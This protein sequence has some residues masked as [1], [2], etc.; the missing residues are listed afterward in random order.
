MFSWNKSIDQPNQGFPKRLNHENYQTTSLLNLYSFP[1]EGRI[2]SEKS[3]SNLERTSFNPWSANR[4]CSNAWSCRFL[5]LAHIFFHLH[6]IKYLLDVVRIRVPCYHALILGPIALQDPKKTVQSS[7]SRRR[8]S[9]IDPKQMQPRFDVQEPLGISDHADVGVV[10]FLLGP[11]PRG[12]ESFTD[13]PTC[14]RNPNPANLRPP[15]NQNQ[16]YQ[17]HV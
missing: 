15:T 12:E 11:T 13:H 10:A 14:R 7:P 5:L 17:I 8:Q 6:L 16:Q 3:L 1:S 9:E 2:R 4:S